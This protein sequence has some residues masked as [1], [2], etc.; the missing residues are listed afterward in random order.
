MKGSNRVK[1]NPVMDLLIDLKANYLVESVKLKQQFY[2]GEI[3]FEVYEQ[4]EEQLSICNKQMQLDL[5]ERRSNA[6]SFTRAFFA[7]ISDFPD[8]DFIFLPSDCLEHMGFNEFYD[9]E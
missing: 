3:C 5:I 6:T 9:E 1:R 7:G 4:A 8:L 2:K